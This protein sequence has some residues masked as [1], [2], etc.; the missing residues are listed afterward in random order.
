MNEA[1]NVINVDG[2]TVRV[3]WMDVLTNPSR[4]AAVPSYEPFL[5]IPLIMFSAAVNKRAKHKG[6][7]VQDY[8]NKYGLDKLSGTS[9]LLQRFNLSSNNK[10]NSYKAMYEIEGGKVPNFY[11][12]N[13]FVKYEPATRHFL[14]ELLKNND[15]PLKVQR[16][17]WYDGVYI[18]IGAKTLSD[19]IDC[20]D[21][22]GE[23]VWEYD[24]YQKYIKTC[25]ASIG[26]IVW[27]LLIFPMF[28]TANSHYFV[29]HKETIELSKRKL[30]QELKG[31][32]ALYV[33]IASQGQGSVDTAYMYEIKDGYEAF[34]RKRITANHGRKL[35]LIDKF[36][37]RRKLSKRDTNDYLEALK[38]VRSNVS[39]MI[40]DTISTQKCQKFID[41][42]NELFES[43]HL[44]KLRERYKMLVEFK[45]RELYDVILDL[46]LDGL[47]VGDLPGYGAIANACS[48]FDCLRDKCTAIR[49]AAKKVGMI[50]LEL[51]FIIYDKWNEMRHFVVDTPK[52]LEENNEVHQSH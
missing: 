8:V 18:P 50:D 33:H 13:D 44:K 39:R 35:K 1:I 4:F 45:Y 26:K 43:A 30:Y 49:A 10:S 27:E 28:D 7:L 21:A 32:H 12:H 20:I 40:A 38:A 37:G 31:T 3:T 25:E 41:K 48:S 6:L 9:G 11:Y 22:S 17:M 16:S 2:Q 47:P 24:D 52:V 5:V 34:E 23:P 14:S 46:R 51:C 19:T 15:T 42:V 29:V 36:I